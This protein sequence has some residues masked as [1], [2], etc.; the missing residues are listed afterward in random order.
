MIGKEFSG[1][2]VPFQM[3]A[4]YKEFGI[5]HTS[6]HVVGGDLQSSKDFVGPLQA[7]QIGPRLQSLGNPRSR[8]PTS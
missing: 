8:Q 3:Y 5:T 1:N 2:L 7:R 6:M 4:S